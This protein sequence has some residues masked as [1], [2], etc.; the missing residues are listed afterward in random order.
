MPMNMVRFT[1]GVN[2]DQTPSLN[3]AA[4]QTT[5][6]IRWDPGSGLPQKIGGWT[7]FYPNPIDSSVT[8]LH[9]WEDLSGVLH[10][11]VGATDSLDVITNGALDNITPQ[12]RTSNPAVNFSTTSASRVV[13]IVD[14]A[15]NATI[16]DALILNTPISIG[17]IVLQ[18][19]YPVSSVISSDSYTI[20]AAATATGTVTNG[21]AVPTFTTISGSPAVSVGLADHGYAAGDT[22]ALI[23]SV[24]VGGLTLL[25]FY[26]VASVT[27]SSV[28]VINAAN[29]ANAS[30]TLSMNGGSAQI[31]YYIT[32]GPPALGT[33]FGNGAFGAGAFGTGVP[34][35]TFQGTPIVT[36]E[37]TLDNFGGFLVAAPQDGPIFV[38]EPESGL[39]TAQMI[40]QAPTVNTGI[41]VAMSA[42][43]IVAYG[44]SVL[45]IKDPL[46]INWCD[47]GEFTI[48]IASVTNL[49]GSFRLSRGSMIVGGLQGPQYALIWTDLDVWSMTFIGAP[50]VF[51]FTE[52]ASGC[53]LLAKFAAGVLGATIYWMSQKQFFAL[54]AGGS[55]TPL[56]CSVWDFVFGQLDTANVAKIRCAPNS[57]FGEVTW[58][59][60]VLGGDGTNQAYVKFTP[61]FNAWDYG[62]L[63]RS[64]W[65]DQSGLGAPI[66]ADPKSFYIYQHETSN[67]AD[68]LPMQPS[69]STGY[70]ALSDGEDYT[71]CDLAIPDMKFGQFGQD[72]DANVS[73]SF[74]YASYPQATT[75]TTP[76]YAMQTNGP[77]FLNVR[78]RARL[79]SMTISSSDAGS[80]WRLGGLRI[81][82]APDGRLG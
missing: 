56:P 71:F 76:A 24:A 23:V 39:Y 73:V 78:F 81:R 17:G 47:A 82:T 58:F 27:S 57:Q 38:W 37:Y 51:S 19:A 68:G 54:A 64:A 14:T 7:K 44:S 40:A 34:P 67:D 3:E 11:G 43:I 31:H 42:Q 59:F 8:A 26:T 35:P 79:A 62:Y 48:W 80:F 15:S 66:G 60:P 45:G 22:F 36:T 10:L 63:G 16:F 13:T 65:T 61:Q 5:Q 75:H 25:G 30:T 29:Q 53:G 18:G 21:G 70:W 1:P 77:A 20:T 72:Q 12:D 55:V 46:V 74:T 50:N 9:A 41:F 28:F 52:L 69:F 33:G 2:V 6:L 49:A 4:Y 32:P